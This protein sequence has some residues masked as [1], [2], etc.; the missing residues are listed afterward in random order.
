MTEPLVGPAEEIAGYR[1]DRVLRSGSLATVYLVENLSLQTQEA[2]K[3]LNAGIADDPAARDRFETE[4]AVTAGLKHPNIVALLARGETDNGNPWITMEYVGGDAETALRHNE[5]SPAR[6]VHIITE[7]ARALDYAHRRGVIHQDIKP[8]SFLL[9][10]RAGEPERV[11]LSDFGSADR[12]RQNATDR[13]A[14]ASVAYAAPEVLRGEPVDARADIYSLGCSFFRLLTGRR[15]FSDETV[16]STVDA[17]RADIEQVPPRLSDYLY[18]ATSELDTALVDTALVNTVLATALA[19]DPS[20]RYATAGQFAAAAKAVLRPGQAPSTQMPTASLPPPPSPLAAEPAAARRPR[21]T[22]LVAAAAGIALAATAVL[23]WLAI[24][25]PPPPSASTPMSSDTATPT[26]PA[27]SPAAIGR[28]RQLLPQG[29]APGTCA[30][31][32]TNPPGTAAVITCLGNDDLAGPTTSTYTLASSAQALE[33]AFAQ[34]TASAT[35]TICPGNI[36]SPGAWKRL[37]DP[38]VPIGTLYCAGRSD[39]PL[40]AWTDDKAMF[41]ATIEALPDGPTLQ[42]LYDWWASHS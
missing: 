19:K 17:S 30:P 38:Y 24:R 35:T 39:R 13:T 12:S 8:S 40:V 16:P 11:V 41:L 36:L 22:P 31:R 9:A 2:L 20:D 18:W 4:A 42:Q 28:L 3:V 10:D 15:P 33:A 5:M 26:E 32:P 27:P 23:V 7:V 25:T 14:T 29:Y 34:L 1:V 6:A 21:R 37:S